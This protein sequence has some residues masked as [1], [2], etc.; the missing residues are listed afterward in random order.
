MRDNA[1]THTPAGTPVGLR[2]T[3]TG[4]GAMLTVD[5]RGPGIPDDFKASVFEPFTQGDPPEHGPDVG[6]GLY[7]V[8]QVAR[9]HGGRAWAVDRAGGGVSFRVLLPT[10]RGVGTG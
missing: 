3:T 7:L 2:V 4:E 10:T 8:A 9:Q 6:L 1:A 5:D